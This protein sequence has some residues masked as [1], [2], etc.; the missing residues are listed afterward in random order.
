VIGCADQALYYVKENGRNRVCV[1]E[2]LMEQ[3]LIEKIVDGS[4][5]GKLEFF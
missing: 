2:T 3:G 1:Y 4:D 5:E